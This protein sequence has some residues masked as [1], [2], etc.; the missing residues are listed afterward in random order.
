VWVWLGGEASAVRALR[1]HF[2]GLGVSKKDIEFAGYWRRSLTQDDAPT[3]DDLA[4][5]RERIAA[6]SE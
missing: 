4:E 1:R 6:L 2:V 5:A 3:A